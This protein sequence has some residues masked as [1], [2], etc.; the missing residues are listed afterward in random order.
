[1]HLVTRLGPAPVIIGAVASHE[2]LIVSLG[3]SQNPFAMMLG[4]PHHARGCL[5]NRTIAPHREGA[6][7]T[8][9]FI[10]LRP[11]ALPVSR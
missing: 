3:N 8:C 10:N 4:A 9:R 11:M 6:L 5:R 7:V 1:M 2:L